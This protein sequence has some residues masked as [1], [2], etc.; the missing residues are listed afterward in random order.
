LNTNETFKT[1]VFSNKTKQNSIVFLQGYGPLKKKSLTKRMF[2]GG[3]D[4]DTCCPG[5]DRARGE[6]ERR[7][8]LRDTHP[9]RTVMSCVQGNHTTTS[10]SHIPAGGFMAAAL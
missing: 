6:E 4:V 1:D 2:G 5:S 7:V 3:Q 9:L 8:F 10:G